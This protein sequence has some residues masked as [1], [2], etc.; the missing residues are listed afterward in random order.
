MIAALTLPT[1][2]LQDDADL[3]TALQSDTARSLIRRGARLYTNG[4]VGILTIEAMNPAR[5]W[6]PGGRITEPSH[7]LEKHPCAA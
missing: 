7:P 5:G 1:L 3:A 4:H 2:I 6:M